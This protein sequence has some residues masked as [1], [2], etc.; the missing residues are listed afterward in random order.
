M[1]S[2][3]GQAL[4]QTPSKSASRKN[5]LIRVLLDAQRSW[6]GSGRGPVLPLEASVY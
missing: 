2:W 5:N 3:G 4:P 6:E 1:L